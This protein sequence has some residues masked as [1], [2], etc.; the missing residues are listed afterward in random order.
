MACVA[1]AVI[2]VAMGAVAGEPLSDLLLTAISVAGDSY[3]I[4][5]QTNG[6][7]AQLPGQHLHFFFN[8]VPTSNAGV[9]GTGPWWI[10][11]TPS[12]YTGVKLSD[13]PSGA[14][15]LCVLV[16]NADHSVQPGTGNCFPLPG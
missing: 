10:Y 14:T 1:V 3:S 9:P 7:T 13:R 16:A 12:P 4:S 15:Q 2:V 11:A 6:F 8:T 5:Y